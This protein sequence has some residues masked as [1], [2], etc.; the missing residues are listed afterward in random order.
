LWVK[1]R[2]FVSRSHGSFRQLPER[3][4]RQTWRITAASFPANSGQILV[5]LLKR[6][7]NVDITFVPFAGSTPAVTALLGGHVT[8]L[9]DNYATVAEHVQAGKLRVLA[10][11][12]KQRS[13]PRP[14]V[15]T[16]AE[17]GF[18]G[19][20][21]DSSC[22]GWSRRQRHRRQQLPNSAAG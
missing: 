14:D 9:F 17:A 18:Q 6:R 4:A 1:T 21:I 5:E 8:A 10:A 11:A 13:E 20:G 12:S 7:A 22:G 2:P 16:V 3:G 15:P 19:Y